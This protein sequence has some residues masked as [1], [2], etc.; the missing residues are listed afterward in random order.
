LAYSAEVKSP[1][2]KQLIPPQNL[3][4]V[5]EKN[6]YILAFSEDHNKNARLSEDGV[7]SSCY[8]C[9]TLEWD[10][11]LHFS[12]KSPDRYGFPLGFYTGAD[13]SVICILLSFRIMDDSSHISR[14]AF[15][16]LKA[17]NLINLQIEHVDCSVI[18][19]KCTVFMSS[20]ALNSGDNENFLF[21]FERER[22]SI[23]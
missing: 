14:K 10:C 19:G 6:F 18:R 15:S 8:A 17:N 1:R 21:V 22:I 3:A 4:A 16:V 13:N 20:C 23:W 2:K 9:S 7:C 5:D 12:L 11:S